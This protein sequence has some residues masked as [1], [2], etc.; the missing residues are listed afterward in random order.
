MSHE[1]RTPLNGILGDAQILELSKNLNSREL[2][3]VGIVKGSGDHLLH[4]IDEILDLSKIEAE[5]LELNPMALHFSRF[6][7]HLVELFRIQSEQ[8]ELVF[9]YIELTPLPAVI[10]AD[11]KRLKQILFNLLGNALRY[12]NSGKITFRVAHVEKQTSF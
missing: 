6:L 11:E 7:E 12:T 10:L 5:K 9:D 1:L 4:L 2:D 3:G 8:K